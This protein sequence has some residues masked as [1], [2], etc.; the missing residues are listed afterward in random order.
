MHIEKIKNILKNYNDK[1]INNILSSENILN[2]C[3]MH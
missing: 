2:L 1:Y 3:Y